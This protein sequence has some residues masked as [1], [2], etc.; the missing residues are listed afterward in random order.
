MHSKIAALVYLCLF[1]FLDLSGCQKAKEETAKGRI[2]VGTYSQPVPLDPL[3]TRETISAQLISLLYNSLTSLNEKCQIVPELAE[4]WEIKEK[5]QKWV[6]HLRRGVLFH[7]GKE[8]S[9]EDVVFTY[10]TAMDLRL[11]EAAGL[12]NLKDIK[13]IDKY[14]VQIVLKEPNVSPL[15]WLCIPIVSER[16]YTGADAIKAVGTGP[17]MLEEWMVDDRITF[18]ANPNYFEGEPDVREIVIRIYENYEAVLSA[19]LR[20]EADIFFPIRTDDPR[21]VEGDPRFKVLSAPS[22]FYYL[23]LFNLQDPVL[24]DK[25]LRQALCYA[26]NREEL[27]QTVLKGRGR[28]AYS[29]FPSPGWTSEPEEEGY[30]PEL[31]EKMLGEL[32]W[33]KDQA[34]GLLKSHN[35]ILEFQLAYP[36]QDPLSRKIA[37]SVWLQLGKIGV[38]IELDPLNAQVLIERQLQPLRYQL[39][40]FRLNTGRDPDFASRFLTTDQIGRWNLSGYTNKTVDSLFALGRTTTNVQQRAEIYQK[41][42]IILKDECPIVPLFCPKA[43]IGV[44]SR[45]ENI[46][47]LKGKDL[48][49]SAKDWRIKEKTG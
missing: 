11:R 34:D 39:A 17:F 28:L 43:F 18:R 20:E 2:V 41:I 14:T 8:L 1:L 22:V 38:R 27:L 42:N 44:N 31:A 10:R 25:K 19:F 49:K 9:A 46:S 15:Y 6:F 12:D 37:N 13:M 23:I 16:S 5:G 4:S 45:I 3:K 47:G 48:L 30:N 21:L 7:D 29:P 32:G 40:I 24:K 26:V 33:K 35:R 36:S